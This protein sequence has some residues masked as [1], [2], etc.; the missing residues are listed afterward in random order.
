VAF[1]EAEGFADLLG[2]G[3]ARFVAHEV[4]PDGGLTEVPALDG[5]GI[6]LGGE[7]DGDFFS[8]QFLVGGVLLDELHDPIAFSLIQCVIGE[9]GGDFVA[10]VPPSHGRVTG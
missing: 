8:E 6:G 4:G 7:F 10:T 1:S 5:L 3:V 2:I 9:V